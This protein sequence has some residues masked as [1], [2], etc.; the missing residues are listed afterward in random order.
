MFSPCS[1]RVKR[2]SWNI[3]IVKLVQGSFSSSEIPVR[4]YS[5]VTRLPSGT[6]CCLCVSR[7]C[8]IHE[9]TQTWSNLTFCFPPQTA[10]WKAHRCPTA[11][12]RP[13]CR[14]CHFFID[15]ER[16]F[17]L[18]SSQLSVF[19]REFFLTWISA[20]LS[21]SLANL[22]LPMLLIFTC[23]MHFSWKALRDS[24]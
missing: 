5:K 14:S 11:C 4:G 2:Q 17:F 19:C 10:T 16:E 22:F 23:S 3:I 9:K 21:L 18:T 6:C 12:S 20:L 13:P 7:T 1:S 15:C 24:K 8:E